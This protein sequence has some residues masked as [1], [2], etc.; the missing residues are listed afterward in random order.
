MT[1]VSDHHTDLC[2]TV[3]LPADGRDA[4]ALP[5]LR[6]EPTDVALADAG[7]EQTQ[8]NSIHSS[9]AAKL[10]R[11]SDTCSRN[12]YHK[13]APMHLTKSVWF[14]CSAVFETFW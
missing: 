7:C 14:D 4:T 11:V 9:A 3:P 1:E 6:A 13:L 2:R 10:I 5:G 8:H 12:L